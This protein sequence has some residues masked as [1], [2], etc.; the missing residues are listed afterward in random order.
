MT[1]NLQ[2]RPVSSK[3]RS[4]GSPRRVNLETQALLSEAN[5]LLFLAERIESCAIR[6]VP[7]LDEWKAEVSA[8]IT[9]PTFGSLGSEHALE[10]LSREL[11]T[12]WL[13][14]AQS[15]TDGCLRSPPANQQPAVTGIGTPLTFGYE[16]E[17][18]PEI[19]EARC[20]DFLSVPPGWVAHH[21]IFSSGQATLSAVLQASL[22]MQ[23]VEEGEPLRLLHLGGYFETQELLDL[24]EARSMTHSRI[25]TTNRDDLAARLPKTDVLLAEIAYCDGALRLLDLGALARTWRQS[26]TRPRLVAFDTTLSGTKFPLE[27]LL[28]MLSG[29]DAPVVV[30]MRSALKLDQGGL[31]L[32]N[33][34]ICS[35]LLPT[36]TPLPLAEFPETLR[37][38]RKL[39]GASIGLQ[40]MASLEAPWFLDRLYG[41]QYCEAIFAHNRQLALAF[42]PTGGLFAGLSHPALTKD[43]SAWSEA[44]FC[45]LTLNDSREENYRRLQ[46]ILEHEAGARQLA[47]SVG[48]SFGFRGHRF[49]SIIPDIP[50]SPSFLRVAL[51]ARGGPSLSGIIKLL[52]QLAACNSLDEFRL[53]R[54]ARQPD[55][56]TE[57]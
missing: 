13:R 19:L 27:M 22:Q 15:A 53:S 43:A 33:A 51:G 39:T 24:F 21:L 42:K 44:P 7:G 38:I 25:R 14:Y 28:G 34:G 16:R 32:A 1:S 20:R 50:E 2:P 52:N 12:L 56:D 41:T 49:E 48:G 40:D 17:L 6:P 11:R 26:R 18:E 29:P 3:A 54:T 36:H 46:T 10:R 30:L 55:N 4:P 45:V 8:L 35:V 9:H 37:K 57:A 31:E 47:F 23:M 5:D